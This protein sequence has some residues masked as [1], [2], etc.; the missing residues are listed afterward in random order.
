MSNYEKKLLLKRDG[1]AA[2][3]I[4]VIP[5]GI[6]I[7][8]FQ[9]L[10]KEK[11]NQKIILFVGRL[12]KYKGIEFLIRSLV[13]MDSDI[14]LE[15]VGTGPYKKS[16]LCLIK[17][18]GIDKKVVFYQNLPRKKLVQKYVN[19]DLFVLLSKHEAFSISVAE[20]LACKT[21]CIVTNASALTDWVDNKNCFGLDNP[22]DITATANLIKRVIGRE[23]DSVPLVGWDNVVSLLANIYADLCYL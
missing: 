12:E 19:A 22:A 5:N 20:A 16:L 7:Q 14:F 3:K 13:E 8:E 15:V 10:K 6:D 9:Y 2:N 17:K 11:T 18:L 23:I 4:Q 21:P 1:F